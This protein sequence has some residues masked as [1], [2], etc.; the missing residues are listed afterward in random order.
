MVTKDIEPY[1]MVGGNPAE[2]IKYQFSSD[3]IEKLLR[4]KWW[5]WSEE[6]VK[7]SMGL[8]CTEEVYS[9]SQML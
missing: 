7:E 5:E 1:A 9:K 6:R 2:V 8:L 3:E 4:M